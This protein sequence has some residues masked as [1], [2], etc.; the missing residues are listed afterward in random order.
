MVGDIQKELRRL[1]RRT[2]H[3]I[4][5]DDGDVICDADHD[6]HHRPAVPAALVPASGLHVLHD[7]SIC[8]VHAGV[9]GWKR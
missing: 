7:R 1:R 3:L 2:S 6:V 9:Q 4:R 5:A 8:R